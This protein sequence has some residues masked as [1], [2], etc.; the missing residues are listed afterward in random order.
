MRTHAHCQRHFIVIKI[1]F[2]ILCS[3]Y[4]RAHISFNFF[5]T[6]LTFLLFSTLLL[7]ELVLFSYFGNL[8]LFHSREACILLL[9]I[10]V[11]VSFRLFYLFLF[12]FR[13]HFFS[14]SCS[15]ILLA[16]WCYAVVLFGCYNLTSFSSMFNIGAN[17]IYSWMEWK[18]CLKSISKGK[19]VFFYVFKFFSHTI[20]LITIFICRWCYVMLAL[21]SL[22]VGNFSL[23][24]FS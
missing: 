6:F 16:F 24:I 9:S 4:V 5:V 18:D 7:L 19:K 2:T 21:L 10:L 17:K 3:A 13:F 20:F 1:W 22:F 15:D 11:R 23:F 12:F 14:A 8:H